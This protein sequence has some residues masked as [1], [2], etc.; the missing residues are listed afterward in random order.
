MISRWAA[1]IAGV[2]IAATLVFLVAIEI[3][4]RNAPPIVIEVVDRNDRIEVEIAGAVAEP[5]VYRRSR[6]D[7][8]IDLI[9]AAGGL[10]PEADTSALNQASRLTDGQRVFIPT[11]TAPGA[12]PEAAALVDL[13]RATAEELTALPGIG[14]VRAEAIVAFRNQNGPFTSINELLHVDGISTTVIDGLRPF[15]TVGP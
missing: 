11:M 10:L 3:D 9:D 1:W 6:G 12:S 2:V 5:G 4:Q 14:A 13:N 15:A 8:V 7:R